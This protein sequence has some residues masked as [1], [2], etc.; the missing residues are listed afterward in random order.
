MSKVQFDLIVVGAGILGLS[1]AI[2]AAEQGL[3]VCILEKDATPIGATRRNFGMVG[4]SIL[5]HPE[6]KWRDYAQ[7]T[8]AF[9]EGI[10]AKQE[11]SFKKS[12]GLFIANTAQEATVLQEFEQRA[13]LYN[14]AVTCLSAAQ[15]KQKFQY[16][17]HNTALD[18]ALVVEQDYS[19]EPHAIASLLLQYAK[20][21]GI[22]IYTDACVV[23]TQ[24][25]D[26]TCIVSLA[27]NIQF[28]SSKVLICH[29]D[30][31][32]LLYPEI[33]KKIGLKRC[34][35]QMLLTEKLDTQLNA[36]LYSGLSI[37]RYPVFEICPSYAALVASSQVGIVKDYGIHVLIKQNQFGELIIGDSHLY[38]NIDEAA[39]YMQKEHI[40]QFIQHYC[41]KNMGV[42]LPKIKNRWTGV[43]LTHDS[44]AAYVH[45][46]EPNI[47]LVGAIAGK[48]MTTGAGY[49]QHILQQH[50]Y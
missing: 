34:T 35:L 2:Q 38:Q 27:S 49:M 3:A 41:Q 10:Q 18:T 48:G 42:E 8:V 40:D 46:A 44:E 31:T 24:S 26:N 6:S 33:L 32:N 15:A 25:S 16:L 13:A 1:A 36:S 30:I 21:L 39:H 23:K 50:I 5:A 19:V 9:Y 14:I 43:Y 7:Q 37:A 47:Y 45:E 20:S 11:I 29:G 17:K 12:Q 22:T 28:T 4:T